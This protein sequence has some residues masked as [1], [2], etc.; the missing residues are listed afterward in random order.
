MTPL[1]YVLILSWNGREYLEACLQSAVGQSYPNRRV[2]LVDNASTDGSQEYVQAAFPEVELLVN[3][4]NLGVAGGRN[5]GIRHALES[6]A[7]Y[8]AILDNDATADPAWVSELVQVARQD[9]TIGMC[10]SKVM[11]RDE[12]T[13]IEWAGSVFYKEWGAAHAML[14]V[15]RGQ[16]DTMTH[17]PYATGSAI[18]VKR[19]VVETVG[20]F[21]EDTGRRG[22]QDVEYG[23]RTWV[24]GYK[25]VYVPTAV[26]YHHSQ[27]LS[28]PTVTVR[29]LN[30]RNSLMCILR[31]YQVTTLL[32]F[33]KPILWQYVVPARY[34]AAHRKALWSNFLMFPRT[35]KRRCHIQAKRRRSDE[36]VFSLWETEYEFPS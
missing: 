6:G 7:D 33:W 36:E 34:S 22:G 17:V 30:V 26:I 10:A 21:D 4:M 24:Y 14:E 5:V 31:N 18:F 23:L 8:I 13:V 9:P 25:V 3:D 11:R 32:K 29:F 35:L 28:D 15:D 27:Q 2:L 1:V 19:E 16:H 12:P 20:L